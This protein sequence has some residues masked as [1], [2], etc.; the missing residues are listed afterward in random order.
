MASHL[1]VSLDCQESSDRHLVMS[2]NHNN[3]FPAEL[4]LMEQSALVPFP[5]QV[6]A[7]LTTEMITIHYL[8]LEP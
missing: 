2:V 1:L 4:W 6:L 8:Q 5:A 7:Q 3:Y